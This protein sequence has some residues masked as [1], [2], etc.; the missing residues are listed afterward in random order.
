MNAQV[1]RPERSGRYLRQP[2]GYRAF[3]PSPLPPDPPLAIESTLQT[4][5]SAADYALGRLDGAVLTLPNPDL[6]VFMYVRK[7]AVLSSQI[8]GTQSSLQQL[9]AAEVRLTEPDTPADVSEVV[10][11]VA[12]MNHG[13]ARLEKLPVSVRLIR[14]IHDVL[15]QGVRGGQHQLL[16][17]KVAQSR[18]QRPAEASLNAGTNHA[19]IARHQ[20]RAIHAPLTF[21][22]LDRHHVGLQTADDLFAVTHIVAAGERRAVG[23]RDVGC[24]RAHVELGRRI[25]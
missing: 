2:S 8:E 6:F 18:S 5:L 7:E 4:L 3:I 10:N 15:L 24:G 17:G 1:T 22:N 11:Y 12:A 14:E 19:Q 20:D 25:G 9:L 21:A 16:L 23:G 13:L